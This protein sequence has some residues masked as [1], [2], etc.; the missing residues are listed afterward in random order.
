MIVVVMVVV[1]VVERVIEQVKL[2]VK[3]VLVLKGGVRQ[4][5]LV[6]LL[7]ALPHYVAYGVE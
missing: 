6:D 3:V 4:P 7:K 5:S 1:V 2:F